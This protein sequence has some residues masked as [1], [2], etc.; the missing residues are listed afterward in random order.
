[1]ELND[2]EIIDD[3]ITQE[4]IDLMMQVLVE[5]EEDLFVEFF[6]DN[7]EELERRIEVAY[8]SAF[9]IYA[10]DTEFEEY[11]TLTDTL[12][13]VYEFLDSLNPKY[14]DDF[15]RLIISGEMETVSEH[16]IDDEP[17]VD[18][19]TFKEKNL[20]NIHIPLDHNLY[21]VYSFVHEFFHTTNCYEDENTDKQFL[22]EMVPIFYE[23]LLFD[24]LR[25]KEVNQ[26]ENNRCIDE[27]IGVF[28]DTAFDLN[29][30][31][32]TMKKA[33][34]GMNFDYEE[35]SPED[36]ER[37]RF[38]MEDDIKYFLA[39]TTAIYEYYEYKNG[40]ISLKNIDEFNRKL[41][42]LDDFDSL[43][44]ILHKDDIE[45]EDLVTSIEYL[46][47]QLK[48]NMSMKR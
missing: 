4:D 44:Y 35:R 19:E 40:G 5:N 38:L 27:R 11:Y 28:L 22:S 14:R 21:D 42:K 45:D 17:Y 46:G 16:D 23:F 43:N 10:G 47:E 41:N 26:L 48:N 29:E 25:T 13:L 34:N 18:M 1:M 9:E 36:T 31:I 8:R 37:L 32:F 6:R 15:N 2:E 39:I 24:F 12:E 7:M 33:L 30:M 3:E 20:L